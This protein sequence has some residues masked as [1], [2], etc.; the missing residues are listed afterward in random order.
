MPSSVMHTVK[1]SAYI[2][3]F[4][5]FSIVCKQLHRTE[6]LGG[7]KQTASS[8]QH[9]QELVSLKVAL[10]VMQIALGALLLPGR[11]FGTEIRPRRFK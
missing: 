9:Y 5:V 6:I 2:L 8:T 7:S 10:A 11:I 1:C 3:L 4:Q